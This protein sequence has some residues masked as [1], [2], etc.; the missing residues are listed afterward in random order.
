MIEA[1]ERQELRSLELAASVRL[2]AVGV[3]RAIHPGTT[4]LIPISAVQTHRV[5]P[6]Q[7][8]VAH[9][10]AVD[11]VLYFAQHEVHQD[12]SSSPPHQLTV[13]PKSPSLPLCVACRISRQIAF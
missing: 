12:D 4:S 9:P 2:R 10:L 7:V 8:A 1:S 3:S 6:H 13:Y 5:P 11:A